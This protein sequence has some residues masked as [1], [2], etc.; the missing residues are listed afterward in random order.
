MGVSR[1]AVGIGITLTAEVTSATGLRIMQE[2]AFRRRREEW[3]IQR[4][5]AQ[6]EVEQLSAQLAALDVRRESAALQTASMKTQQRQLRAG[7]RLSAKQGSP[8][9]RFTAGCVAV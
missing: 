2:E 4:N 5:N 7:A 1:N 6:G 8:M 3:E 9:W